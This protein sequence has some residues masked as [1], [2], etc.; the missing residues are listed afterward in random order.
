ME[1]LGRSPTPF[2][3]ASRM[4]K[5]GGQSSCYNLW[6]KREE[7]EA[8]FPLCDCSCQG[9]RPEAGAAYHTEGACLRLKPN[10]REALLRSGEEETP[11]ES[12]AS[13]TGRCFGSTGQWVC[14]STPA[15]FS[16]NRFEPI[17]PLNGKSPMFVKMLLAASKRTP[18]QKWLQQQMFLI[19]YNRQLQGYQF[20]KTIMRSRIWVS[21]LSPWQL[22]L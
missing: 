5:P 11:P 21:H 14:N 18:A 7:E 1:S 17:S 15:N 22:C 2:H 13:V 19:S 4:G 8:T 9:S 16:L 10:Q 12:E 6:W 3:P 20:N